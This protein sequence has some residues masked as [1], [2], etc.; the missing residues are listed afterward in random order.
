MEELSTVPIWAW[1]AGGFVGFLAMRVLW[2]LLK[3]SLNT[4][5]THGRTESGLLNQVLAERDKALAR[6]EA[7]EGRADKYFM[8]LAEMRT[9]VRLLELQ[10]K[11]A[12]EKIDAMTEKFNAAMGG[13]S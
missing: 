6:A 11:I 3:L 13:Q 12:T 10:L 8:E 1:P 4:Q 2:P 5:L 7:A 9:Q